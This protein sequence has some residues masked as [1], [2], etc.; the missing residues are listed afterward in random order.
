MLDTAHV[1][2]HIAHLKA[3][4]NKAELY[5]RIPINKISKYECKR[6]GKFLNNHIELN[7]LNKIEATVFRPSLQRIANLFLFACHTGLAFAELERFVSSE[8]VQIIDG[9]EWIVMV[10]KKTEANGECF[11]VPVFEGTKKIMA[12]MEYVLPKISNQKYNEHLKEIALLCGITTKLTTH[13][14]R[15]TFA[16]LATERYNF[17]LESISYML[18][19]ADIKTTQAHYARVRLNTVKNEFVRMMA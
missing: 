12:R 19:H 16:I 4:L 11:Y 8:H 15:K 1:S 13:S 10:R 7:Q 18:G 17:S 14:A 2:R 3:I 5:E 6:K 9:K